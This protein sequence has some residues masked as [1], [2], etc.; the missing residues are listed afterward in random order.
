[1]SVGQGWMFVTFC[2]IL[3]HFVTCMGTVRDHK[4]VPHGA[5]FMVHAGASGRFQELYLPHLI[6]HRFFERYATNDAAASSVL[7]STVAMRVAGC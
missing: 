3:W 5:P 6:V 4:L 1:M 7:R 2:D